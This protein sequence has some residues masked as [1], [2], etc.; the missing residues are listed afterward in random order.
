MRDL[1]MKTIFLG[2]YRQTNSQ[3]KE[4]IEWIVLKEDDD[5]MYVISKYCLDCVPY[6]LDGK[7]AWKNSF[8]RQWLNENF[9]NEAFS[10]EEQER[11]LLSDVKTSCDWSIPTLDRGFAVQDKVFLPSVA[12]M[13]LF[14]GSEKWYDLAAEQ[15][16]ITRP[17][18]FAY[19]NG[20]FIFPL[21][22][23]TYGKK[24][25][26]QLYA[27]H[28]D[29][30]Y[31]EDTPHW[32]C[33]I[34]ALRNTSFEDDTP[35]KRLGCQWYL[36]SSGNGIHSVDWEGRIQSYTAENLDGTAIRPAMWIKK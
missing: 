17:T 21:I 28:K 6:S 22:S 4:P 13:I 29:S 26:R 3:E 11:I 36:R 27:I 33:D 14:F 25:S 12:E 7:I 24:E 1:T 2:N 8:M 19:E 5:K 20:S 15:K 32:K 34:S 35:Q 16:R 23:K 18:K 10:A 9:L 31:L 30:S